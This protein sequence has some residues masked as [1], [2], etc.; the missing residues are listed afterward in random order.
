MLNSLPFHFFPFKLFPPHSF[1][2]SLL[3]HNF[4]V[5]RSLTI[6]YMTTLDLQD[7]PSLLPN[8]ATTLG[9][10]T[11]GVLPSSITL[12]LFNTKV[13]LNEPPQHFLHIEENGEESEEEPV[14]RIEKDSNSRLD[15]KLNLSQH[16]KARNSIRSASL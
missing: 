10:D 7:H 6:A 5:D 9:R 12:D 2:P 3:S 1:F 14:G 13:V 16:R 15:L 4:I 8:R 11:S